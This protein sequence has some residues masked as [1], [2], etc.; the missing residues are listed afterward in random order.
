M[1][2]IDTGD[3][4]VPGQRRAPTTHPTRPAPPTSPDPHPEARQ[5][6]PRQAATTPEPTTSDHLAGES[7]GTGSAR[8]AGVDTEGFCAAGVGTPRA[9]TAGV[10]AEAEATTL[11]E[12]F[13]RACDRDPAALAVQC[14]SARC[15]Y[16]ELDA[17]ANRLAHVLG[18][19]GVG[20]GDR[21]G[22]LLDR[23]IET[24]VSILG[25][26]KAGAAYVPIDSGTPADRLTFIAGDSGLHDLVTTSA[27]LD[28]LPPMPCPVL[29]LD[30]DARLGRAP[31]TRPGVRPA[32]EAESYVIYTSG[33]TGKP[34]GVAVS[35]A[36]IV[37]FLRVATPIYGVTPADRVYQGMSIG[38]D[39]H[40]EEMWP[41]W[42]AGAALIA[43]P[44]DGRRFGQGLVDFL[45]EHEVSVLCCVPTMLTTLESD[46]ATVRS[47]LVSGEAMPPDLV[48][49]FARPGRRILNC[50]GP[51]ETTVSSSCAELHPGRP[52]TLGRPFPT[53][54]FYILDSD[55]RPVRPGETGEICIGGPGVALGYVNR[56]ELTAE[57]FVPNPVATDRAAAPTIYRTGDLGRVTPTGEY[58][59]LGRIDTQVKI[60]GFR[61]ELGEIEQVIRED[62][63][64]ET[65]VV[66]AVERDGVVQD[67][68]GYVT[69]NRPQPSPPGDPS[70]DA[71]PDPPGVSQADTSGDAQVDG[72]GVSQ[73]GPSGGVQVGRPGALQV[74][75]S[76]DAQ[77]DASG[78]SGGLQ[79]DRPS[80]RQADP[81]G[82]SRGDAE[83]GSGSATGSGSGGGPQGGPHDDGS[84]DGFGC[85][86]GTSGGVASSGAGDDGPGASDGLRERLHATLR[87]RLPAYMIP[88]FIEVLDELPLL[89][90]GKVD[91]AALPAPVSAPLGSSS[92]PR[93]APATPVE[94]ELAEEWARVLGTG[95]VSVT[96]DFFCDLGGHSLTAARLISALRGRPG[97]A[98][99]GMGDLY[100]HPT[101][102]DLAAFVSAA[103]SS[104]AAPSRE[105]TG[106]AP[107]RHSSAR[108]WA[109]GVAQLL[110]LQL[111]LLLLGAP[112]LLLLYAVLLRFGV[113][114]AIA[115]QGKVL[116]RL[117]ALGIVPL[118]ALWAGWFLTM[119]FLLPAVGG[120][121][122]LRG[123]APGWHPL[124][125]VT[126]LRF[127]LY[128]RV[129]A[130]AP[131]GLL[132]G[133]P[134]MSPYLRLLGAKIGRH[135]HISGTVSVPT[136]VRVG[137]GTSIGFLARVQPY[138]VRDGWL[139]LA[140]VCIGADAHIGANSVVLAGACVGDGASVGEQSLVHAD[141]LI[142]DGEHWAG[143][144]AA[145]GRRP[146]LLET[147]AERADDR[148]WTVPVVAGYL[149]GM[150]LL[151]LL[152]LVI[153]LPSTALLIVVAVT[154]GT[155]A[156]LA[157]TVAA[158][159]LFVLTSCLVLMGAIRLTQPTRPPGVHSARG[160]FALR[161]WLAMNVS[162]LS[163][164][165]TRTI[166]C[167]LYV[168]PFLR[169]TGLRLGRWCEIAVPAFIDTRMTV[170]GDECFLAGGIIVAPPVYHRGMLALGRAELDRRGF[171]GNMAQVPG[172]RR[173]GDSS[174]LGVL[175]VAPARPMDPETTWLGSP[176]IFLPRRQ[177]SQSF[178]ERLLYRPTRA[179]VVVRLL[180]ELPRLL[181]PQ[182]ILSA[183]AVVGIWAAIHLASAL[184]VLVVPAVMPPLGLAL[185][186][187]AT[188][189]VVALKWL[190]IGVYRP[191]VEPYW[192]IWVRRT[193]LITGLF[194]TV[195]VPGLAGG[196][197][198]TPWLAPLLRLFGV[199]IGRRTWLA[200]SGGT[201]FDLVHI[202]D[203]AAVG[204][205]T[206]VQTH[207][208][209]D[210]VMKMS[211]VRVA[212]GA[213]VG[214]SAVVL[215]DAEVGRAGF[216]DSLSL[217][218]KGELL[219]PAT[220]W[221]GIP[222]RPT[223]PASALGAP[224]QATL[225]ASVHTATGPSGQVTGEGAE[226][227][228]EGAG[229]RRG[230]PR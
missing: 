41:A 23:S 54:V 119:L 86:R 200:T 75:P 173:M 31:A 102:R 226:Q 2:R 63:A 87:R 174:L 57:R 195:V 189:V 33:T 158:G 205:G 77:P 198:G 230:G 187:A 221:R 224:A 56:P 78:A 47:I 176:P 171:V 209:E 19:R 58:E 38:F 29:T 104:P 88:S 13:E 17:R 114:V 153:A 84:R 159:P 122:I 26:L 186:L 90:A 181:L 172:D 116:T 156:T 16:G 185:G 79:V 21:V 151:T 203:D 109:C 4:P 213:S 146:E 228:R 25:V 149:A 138:D 160:G 65:A 211:H 145:P 197:Y 44:A 101:V 162:A 94:A 165:L 50:Y 117:S 178:P 22:I 169:A 12:Y 6:P 48:R 28:R 99:L 105:D 46:P 137:S 35:H 115:D 80:G 67:L 124:W 126:Y 32:P 68:V 166:Y 97:M 40:L 120:R 95:E 227:S 167:T 10:S 43:G 9:G 217:A 66:T 5:N 136:F 34:K 129:V 141:Q 144:P 11:A 210:R 128:G 91:R 24:Y 143:S 62:D 27:C 82:G 1:T 81:S 110:L 164:T 170:L 223:E 154:R 107:L 191:R 15:R 74:D 155:Q 121:L 219:P 222:A 37:N 98:H 133:T 39:F 3:Q 36:S 196:L 45:T 180:V 127:W 125:G 30:T 168:L 179:Q 225:D 96:D 140:P 193:E 18:E 216:L 52:V 202:G 60:R 135:C 85:G 130:L 118:A 132:A 59:Y 157:A 89:A 142:P 14:G 190:V 76:G 123:I 70:G 208:F 201:E 139:R 182:I 20:V 83:G 69:L 106:P 72:P 147:M 134:L 64:V 148:P 73:V 111:W 194:E 177:A 175:S 204:D 42:I 229:P 112:S 206:A 7:A 214:G 71:Q 51:T 49:R 192:S 113:D 199:H 163:I 188:L 212:D 218:M 207:L 161:K 131:L 61:V 220:R 53:Y 100:A 92:G 55:L 108:V 103:P 184:P 93:T 8:T 183:S 150:L 215:Y 152:P